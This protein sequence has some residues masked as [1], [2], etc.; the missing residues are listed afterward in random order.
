MIQVKG[1]TKIFHDNK[2]GKVIAVD[3][4]NFHCQKGKIFGLLGPNGAG[5]T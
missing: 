3:N 5:K 4:L 1:L 2:R